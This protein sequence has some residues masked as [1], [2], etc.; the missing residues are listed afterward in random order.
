MFPKI[1]GDDEILDTKSKNANA[2]KFK[3]CSPTLQSFSQSELN[4]LIEM[5]NLSR[6]LAERLESSHIKTRS[7]QS[8]HIKTRCLQS[9]VS[10][11]SYRSR[12]N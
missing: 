5:L 3:A 9:G 10:I 8:S 7:L 11:T 2:S 6:Q 1:H 4:D 12:A